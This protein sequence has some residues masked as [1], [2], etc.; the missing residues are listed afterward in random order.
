MLGCSTPLC[1]LLWISTRVWV[2]RHVAMGYHVHVTRLLSL[3]WSSVGEFFPG[4]RDHTEAGVKIRSRAFLTCEP[5]AVPSF[6][7]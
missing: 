7:P 6:V 1:E 4:S 2:L 3:T 5:P